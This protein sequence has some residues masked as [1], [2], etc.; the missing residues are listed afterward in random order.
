MNLDDLDDFGAGFDYF[1]PEILSLIDNH[2]TTLDTPDAKNTVQNLPFGS[3]LSTHHN[4][5]FNNISND[6]SNVS[7]NNYLNNIPGIDTNNKNFN[8]ATNLH[9]HTSN[10]SSP[11]QINKINNSPLASEQAVLRP[12]SHTL[13]SVKATAVVTPQQ[14]VISPNNINSG[15]IQQI[16][17]T[18]Q[19]NVDKINSVQSQQ[20]HNQANLSTIQ[21]HVLKQSPVTNN[22]RI[23]QVVHQPTIFQQVMIPKTESAPNCDVTLSQALVY[24]ATPTIATIAT[25]IQTID[26]TTV[27]TSIPVVMDS[28]SERLPVARFVSTGT[29]NVVHHLAKGERRNSHNAIE[30][31]YRCSINDK[32]LELKNLVA[33]EEAKVIMF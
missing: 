28:G 30:K 4:G 21:A 27:L 3:N 10:T 2:N 15:P 18:Q 13:P 17:T 14:S 19:N 29:N 31:R 26:N 5:S 7:A 11:I 23:S 32:I 8:I 1:E 16:I 25:P 33:G 22:A 24:K 9:N 20:I 6:L 12:L